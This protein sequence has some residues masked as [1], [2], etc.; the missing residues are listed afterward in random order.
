LA[1]APTDAEYGETACDGTPPEVPEGVFARVLL[2]GET[3]ATPN[4]LL[5][6]GKEYGWA[7]AASDMLAY[8]YSISYATFNTTSE[9]FLP[10]TILSGNVTNSIGSGLGNV[11]VGYYQF[12]EMNPLEINI[13]ESTTV[14][15]GGYF[16]LH[17]PTPTV[18]ALALAVIAWVDDND[19]GQIDREG[20]I[21]Q[22]F[23][24][25][26]SPALPVTFNSAIGWL[27]VDQPLEISVPVSLDISISGSIF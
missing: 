4:Q 23:V 8:N 3:E 24:E 21:I 20:A 14:D 22:T 1:A 18:P 16:E 6:L 15:G 2:T 11:K 25:D 9:G 10:P 26:R 19:N 13:V 27:V 5:L 7:V 12:D 17:L